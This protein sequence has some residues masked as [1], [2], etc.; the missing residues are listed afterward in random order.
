MTQYHTD[1]ATVIRCLTLASGSACSIYGGASS[2]GGM[3]S[4]LEYAAEKAQGMGAFREEV[5]W[6]LLQA[7]LYCK[8]GSV[9]MKVGKC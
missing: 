4:I 3:K 8:E 7:V 9:M 6:A 1:R 5:V 2:C